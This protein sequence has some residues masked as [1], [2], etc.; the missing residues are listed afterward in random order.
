MKRSPLAA[1][2]AVVLAVSAAAPADVMTYDGMGLSARAVLHAPGSFVDGQRIPMGQYHMSYLGVPYIGYCVDVYQCVGD[3]QVD[4][5][6]LDTLNTPDAYIG[7]QVA[8]LYDTYA[9]S[10]GD[11]TS[12]A[13]LAVAIWEMVFETAGNAPDPAAGDFYISGN[14]AVANDAADKLADMPDRYETDSN[15]VI[16]HSDTKQDMLILGGPGVPEPAAL[17]LLAVGGTIQLARRRHR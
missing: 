11:G 10:V 8:W 4:V 2:A 15:L 17:I 7:E 5:L 14:E 12:A 9:A 3:T 6:G 13:G 16:L 1:L